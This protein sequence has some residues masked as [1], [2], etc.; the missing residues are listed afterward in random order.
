[1]ASTAIEDLLELGRSPQ[2]VRRR[3]LGINSGK[4]WKMRQ[5]AKPSGF[6]CFDMFL[7]FFIVFVE[8]SSTIVLVATPQE[9]HGL[10][11]AVG[12]LP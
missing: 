5:P 10:V 4:T 9:A 12:S 7:Y 2:L 6:S 11:Q 1:M 8:T 3:S